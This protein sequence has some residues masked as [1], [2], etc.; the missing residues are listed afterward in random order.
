M[1]LKT[2]GLTFLEI[3]AGLL[4]ISIFAGI[5][6]PRLF[7]S[8]ERDIRG[9]F[10]DKF[11]QLL[12][13]V[14]LNARESHLVHKIVFDF[15]RRDIVVDRAK[16]VGYLQNLDGAFFERTDMHVLIPESIVINALVVDGRSEVDARTTESWFFVDDQGIVQSV[17]LKLSVENDERAVV[18]TLNP[19][20]NTFDIQ[21][22]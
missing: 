11:Q 5:M 19:F 3:L 12:Q 16:S 9:T 17:A 6:V 13:D 14:R 7:R 8:P 15:S 4:I 20:T 21:E 22:E 2:N 1:R 10:M 18:Y